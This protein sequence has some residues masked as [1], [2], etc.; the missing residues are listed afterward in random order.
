MMLPT[1]GDGHCRDKTA[2]GKTRNLSAGESERNDDCRQRLYPPIPRFQNAFMRVRTSLAQWR[3]TLSA[4]PLDKY[5]T[6]PC[7]HAQCCRPI[8]GFAVDAKHRVCDRH[9]SLPYSELT[10][11]P[12]GARADAERSAL[13][14]VELNPRLRRL[15]RGALDHDGARPPDNGPFKH[16]AR[17]R[18]GNTLR[19]GCNVRA[20][21]EPRTCC[22]EKMG[23]PKF[24]HHQAGPYMLP[25]DQ[26]KRPGSWWRWTLSRIRCRTPNAVKVR[27]VWL[28]QGGYERMPHSPS[29][30]ALGAGPVD[31]RVMW[32]VSVPIFVIL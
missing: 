26:L 17:Y 22:D 11:C 5:S 4:L 27:F 10:P 14:L 12:A 7:A 3:L 13:R 20:L 1:A 19:A 25:C 30:G 21:K 18:R 16:S 8:N 2:S 15:L 9:I 29:G 31:G 32:S 24:G 23:F 6:C 28:A